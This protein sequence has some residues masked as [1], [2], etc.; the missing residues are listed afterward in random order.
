MGLPLHREPRFNSTGRPRGSPH[1]LTYS[2]ILG[3]PPLPSREPGREGRATGRTC[4]A[5]GQEWKGQRWGW[6]QQSWDAE[7]RREGAGLQGQAAL[8]ASAP[9]SPCLF[10]LALLPELNEGRIKNHLLEQ[11]RL[12]R[13]SKCFPPFII[14]PFCSKKSPER[15]QGSKDKTGQGCKQAAET[16]LRW[17]VW[18]YTDQNSN[19]ASVNGSPYD[20]EPGKKKPL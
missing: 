14:P 6:G 7:S 17:R 1:H 10:P 16:A 12:G 5:L 4:A 9:C 11:V 15:E 2:R 8:S 3:S 18:S 20:H 19:P 13:K